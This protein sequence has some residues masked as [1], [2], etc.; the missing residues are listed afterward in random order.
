M[1]IERL[2]I[3]VKSKIKLKMSGLRKHEK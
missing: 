1:E 2:K 3:F